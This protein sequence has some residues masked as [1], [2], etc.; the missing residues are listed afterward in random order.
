MRRRQFIE[1][2]DLP[3]W[4]Q[5]FRDGVTDYLAT[6]IRF[7]KIHRTVAPRL[8]AA[9]QRSG[10]NRIT[11]LCSGAGG[12]WSELLPELTTMGATP[13][14][15]LTDKFPNTRALSK[16]IAKIPQAR[17]EAQPAS[18]TNMPE[19]LSG[20]RTLFTAFHHFEPN[21]AQA[22]LQ[23]AVRD[24]QGIAIFE[25]A[26][27]TPRA[28]IFMLCIPLTVCL[29]TPLIRPFRW[30]RL[31][32]TYIL[33]VIPAAAMFDAIVSCLRM[34]TPEEMLTM[35][36]Q[37]GDGVFDWEAGYDRT[38][39]LPIRIPYLIGVPRRT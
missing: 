27:R 7:T 9:I 6:S 22:I 13:S 11:D 10:A 33:P 26:S 34:Y 23:A 17:F 20:F 36:R 12:P 30:S 18:A 37:V 1:L 16:L 24:R 39:G 4:P 15:C 25:G 32:W 2:E 5:V 3:W 19:H 8:A 29:M 21:D 14:L 28:L 31:F 35:A 38:A